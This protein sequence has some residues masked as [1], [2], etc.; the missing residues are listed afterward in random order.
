MEDASTKNRTAC[1]LSATYPLEKQLPI[2]EAFWPDESMIDPNTG[3]VRIPSRNAFPVLTYH[4][5]KSGYA[6]S[7]GMAF[8]HMDVDPGSAVAQSLLARPPG[9]RF[10]V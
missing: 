6:I 2:P 3:A 9:S 7:S 5:D 10:Y 4:K 8:T 1:T